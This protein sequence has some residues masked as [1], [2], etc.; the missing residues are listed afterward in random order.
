MTKQTT[1]QLFFLALSTLFLCACSDDDD[2][3]DGGGDADTDADSDSDTD[4]DSDSDTDTDSD[5]DTDADSDSDGDSDSEPSTTIGGN[6]RRCDSFDTKML[7]YTVTVHGD[8][9]FVEWRLYW[10][11]ENVEEIHPMTRSGNDW[12]LSLSIEAQEGIP[13]VSTTWDCT[14]AED[15]GLSQVTVVWGED[16]EFLACKIEGSTTTHYEW[17]C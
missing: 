1:V 11:Q 9:D 10:N 3:V 12:T 5:S 8:A 4:T 13:G 15:I 6:E 16:G 14:I 17:E 7:T 2:N